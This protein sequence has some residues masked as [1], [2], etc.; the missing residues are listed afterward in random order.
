MGI[1]WSVSRES[2]GRGS[3]SYV[4]C[5]WKA[6]LTGESLFFDTSLPAFLFCYFITLINLEPPFLMFR[7][8]ANKY[9]NAFE[10]F[11]SILKMLC[12]LYY[13]LVICIMC[14]FGNLYYLCVW[15][16]AIYYLCVFQ[17]IL[18][19]ICI[20]CVFGHLYYLCVWQ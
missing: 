4:G 7:F 12:S 2:G 13:C 6:Q 17:L 1:A 10:G 14:V 9:V 16:L 18:F 20:I 11:Q 15:Q 8:A 5:L 3:L 19:V